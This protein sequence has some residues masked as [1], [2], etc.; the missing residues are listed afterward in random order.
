[1]P[2]AWLSPTGGPDAWKGTDLSV[3]DYIKF[4]PY[5]NTHVRQG[6]MLARLDK[7]DTPMSALRGG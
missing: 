2:G 4:V 3:G 6:T 5:D 7:V 1:M